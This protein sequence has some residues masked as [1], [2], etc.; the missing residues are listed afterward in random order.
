MK[1][2]KPSRYLYS[3]KPESERVNLGF[4]LAD[5]RM[6]DREELKEDKIQALVKENLTPRITKEGKLEEAQYCSECNHE[7]S[8]LPSGKLLCEGCG[9]SILLEDNI[10]LTSLNQDLVPHINQL[11]TIQN[12]EAKPFFYSPIEDDSKDAPNYEVIR[13]YENGRI[14]HIRLKK[15]VSPTEYRIFD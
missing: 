7:L 9:N 13:S 10:P 1:I 4:H 5:R 12:E 14:Q 3:Q 8:L 15:G 11:D 6:I 2:Y